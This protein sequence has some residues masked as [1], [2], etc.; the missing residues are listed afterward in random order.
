MSCVVSCE[1]CVADKNADYDIRMCM[2]HKY[3]LVVQ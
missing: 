3:S 2:M 1:D